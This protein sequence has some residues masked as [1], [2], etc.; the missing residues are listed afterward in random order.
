LW[1]AAIKAL[2]RHDLNE[3]AMDYTI[4]AYAEAHSFPL[5]TYNKKHFVWLKEVY[6]P[7]ELMKKL[8]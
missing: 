3:N 5:I 7:E 2:Q 6:T 8:G 4:G 1:T